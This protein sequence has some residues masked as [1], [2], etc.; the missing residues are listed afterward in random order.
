MPLI[1][2]SVCLFA[3]K[4]VTNSINIY[5]PCLIKHLFYYY[6]VFIDVLSIFLSNVLHS[7][8][9]FFVLFNFVGQILFFSISTIFQPVF[10]LL[11]LGDLNETTFL[12]GC[13]I[14]FIGFCL[15]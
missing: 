8:R 7:A 6:F 14:F 13:I 11:K 3:Y 9:L 12:S 10:F 5:K 4:S 2:F 15:L 1:L